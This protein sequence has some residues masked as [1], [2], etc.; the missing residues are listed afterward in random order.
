MSASPKTRSWPALRTMDYRAQST[1]HGTTEH[2]QSGQATAA[3]GV[4]VGFIV[5]DYYT[6]VSELRTLE[7]V[8]D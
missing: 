4:P 8:G 6:K 2:N 7:G 1:H 5:Y 3:A